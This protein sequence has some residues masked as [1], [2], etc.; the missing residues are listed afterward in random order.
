MGN[1]QAQGDDISIGVDRVEFIST[2]GRVITE[3]L[4]KGIKFAQQTIHLPAR[5]Q[6]QQDASAPVDPLSNLGNTYSK[7]QLS[8]DR[9]D[10]DAV[11]SELE[12]LA[13]C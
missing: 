3:D 4:E 8:G 7:Y 2:A 11:A 12:N 13:V 5:D 9:G 6:P 10:S 1:G